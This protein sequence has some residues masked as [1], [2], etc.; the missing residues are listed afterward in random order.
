MRKIKQMIRAVL[1]S[2]MLPRNYIWCWLH[3]LRP[4][5]T[6]RF[7]GLPYI[8]I[9]GCNAQIEIGR[10]F[11][12]VSKISCN[13]VGIIQ[14][15]MLKVLDN[16]A[17]I[18][19]GDDVGLSGCSIVSCKSITIGNN[20]LIGS[21]AIVADSD[22]HPIDPDARRLGGPGKSAPI[23]IEADVFVGARAIIL[24]GVTIGRG[25]VVG[26]GAVVTRSVPEFSVVVGNPAKIVGH[27]RK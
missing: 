11:S 22:F 27:S 14:P 15:V 21:G 24:K 16:D 18:R 19:I 4:D 9:S 2:L 5:F 23:V 8:K 1:W 6:W 12:A 26:A 3:G 25:S 10:R 13:A 20:V 7:N 17:R